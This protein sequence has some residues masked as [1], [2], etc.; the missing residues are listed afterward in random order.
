VKLAIGNRHFTTGDKCGKWREK[1]KH[2]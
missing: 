1:A 2:Y